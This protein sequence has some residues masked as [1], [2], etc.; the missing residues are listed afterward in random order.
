MTASS[1]C[2]VERRLSRN[3]SLETRTKMLFVHVVPRKGLPHE[4]GVEVILTVRQL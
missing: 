3:K 4:H 1:G 2:M